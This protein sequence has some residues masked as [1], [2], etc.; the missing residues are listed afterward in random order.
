LCCYVALKLDTVCFS[1]LL[2]YTVV[3]LDHV[4]CFMSLL[5]TQIKWDLNFDAPGLVGSDLLQCLDGVYQT[6]F[7]M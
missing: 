6:L 2:S 1:R 4:E 3:I 5:I 7:L